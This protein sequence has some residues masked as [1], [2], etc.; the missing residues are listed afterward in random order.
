MIDQEIVLTEH[1]R[2][3]IEIIREMK[4]GELHIVVIKGTP[5]RAEEIRMDIAL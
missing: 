1:D 3:L 5:V 4:R 2:R